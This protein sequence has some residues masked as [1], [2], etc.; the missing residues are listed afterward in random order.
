MQYI[1]GVD[2]G[3]TNIVVGTVAADGSDLSGLIVRKT[4]ASQGVEAVVGRVVEMI[5]ESRATGGDGEVI[6]VG[7]GAPGPISRKTGV[8]RIAPNL[9]WREVP[10]T[11]L[12]HEAV[13]LPVTLDNDANCAVLGEWWQGAG[14]EVRRLIGMTVGTG[15]GGG[16]VIGGKIWHGTSDVAGEF[17]HMTIDSTG[18]RCSCGNY[19]CLEAYASGPNIAQRAVESLEAGA[20]SSLSSYVD[21]D[22]GRLTAGEVYQAA[23]DGDELASDI[24]KD[25]ARFLGI[26]VANLI[27]I[28][29]PNVVLV[30]GGV[31]KAGEQLFAPLRSEVNR[32][33]FKPA[34]EVCKILPGELHGTAGVYGAV[35]SFL[36]QRQ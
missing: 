3:G 7:V 23:Q 24:V 9:R 20:E 28:F 18:R 16:I 10:I 11:A 35:K 5:Q 6:G 17:G 33:A 13:G 31:T 8:V 14:G 34:S 4:E 12:I 15:I 30:M 26:G 1:T 19:G 36:A 22:L 25:T 29:N 2:L 27:N 32:R 21:G